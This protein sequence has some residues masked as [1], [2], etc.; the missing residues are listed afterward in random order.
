VSAPSDESRATPGLLVAGAT[1]GVV[2]RMS[3]TSAAAPSVARWIANWCVAVPGT[4]DIGMLR[5][6][7]GLLPGPDLVR[8]PPPGPEVVTGT[9]DDVCRLSRVRI[10]A[11]LEPT[12]PLP[13][14]VMWVPP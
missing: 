13:G 3:G 11:L 5:E 9:V 12:L 1:S 2:N 7:I 14:A 8:G 6:T 4:V 10:N